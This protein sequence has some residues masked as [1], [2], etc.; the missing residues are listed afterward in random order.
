MLIVSGNIDLSVGSVLGFAGGIAAFATRRRIWAAGRRSLLA[1]VV[2][3]AVGLFQ[4]TLTAYLNIPAFIVTLGRAAGVARC[5][6]M[7]AWRQH[8]PDFGRHF[9][10]DR[11]GQSAAVVGWVLAVAAIAFVIFMAYRKARSVKTTASA[12][13]ITPAELLKDPDPDRC[14]HRVYFC[15]EHRTRRRSRKAV[16]RFRFLFCWWS[17][18]SE[19][20]LDELDDLWPI[21]VRDRRQCGRGTALGH[22]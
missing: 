12:K 19:R 2:G 17:L 1:I 18:C 11:P 3:V 5:G 4:G 21:P 7:A 8:Y 14:D 15:D 16:F 9:Q 20:F 13:R 6:Q 10:I 22:Q